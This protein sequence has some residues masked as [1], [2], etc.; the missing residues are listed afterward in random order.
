MVLRR[1]LRA[2][3][4]VLASV[5]AAC[6]G[7]G[8][9][10]DRAASPPPTATAAELPRDCG[11]LVRSDPNLLNLLYPDRYATYWVAALPIPPGGEI[12]LEGRYP[13]ARY[14]SFNLYNPRLE[15]IDALADVEIAPEPG[16]Q[17]P[18]ALGARRDATARDYRVRVIAAVPPAERASR[19]SNTL[20]SYAAAGEQRSASPLTV[21]IYRLYVEDAGYDISGG[22]GLPQIAVK[23][24]DGSVLRGSAACSELERLP[25][26]PAAEALNGLDPPIDTQ[27]NTAAFADLQWL[28]FFDLQGSQANRFNAVPGLGDALSDNFGQSTANAGGFASNV[29]NNYIYATLSQS[30][31]EVVAIE[32]RMPTTPHTRNGEPRMGDGQLRYWSL[33]NNEANSQRYIDCLHDEQARRV[34]GERAIVLVSR[35][36]DRPANAIAECG[37]NW[38]NWGPFSNSLI[39]YR[40]MLPRGD[41]AQ[42]IQRIPGPAG[43]H[44]REVMGEYYPYGT[45]LSKAAFEALGCPVDPDAIPNRAG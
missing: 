16:S 40:H 29:H 33:C 3:L 31:G 18:F 10:S 1:L 8:S 9:E 26:A 30:L 11:W 35:A 38:L 43:D 23:L 39:I 27:P 45:H 37:V 13:H 44:E 21:A 2:A 41:F 19:E 12:W 25:S 4:P 22:V 17:Q 5:L 28:K 24:A 15:P 34:S 32:A 42:A 6:G 7:G 20:Y 36:A 14:A